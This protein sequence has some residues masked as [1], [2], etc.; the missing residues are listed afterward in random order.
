[1]ENKEKNFVSSVIY[2]HNAYGRIEEF[3]KMVISVMEG[4]FEHSEIICVNDFSDDDSLSVIRSVSKTAV[5]TSITIVNMSYFHGLELAMKAGMDM[6]IGDFVFEFDNTIMDYDPGEIYKIY[7][8][9]LEGY[10]IVSASPNK[11]EKFTSR[12]YYRTFDRFSNIKYEMVTESFRILS[13]R[14]INRIS[15]MNSSIL[16]RKA[17]YANCGLKTDCM[18]YEVRRNSNAGIDK[19]EK[20]FRSGLAVDSLILFTEVGYRFSMTM[21]AL[22]MVVSLLTIAYTIIIYLS[23]NPVAGWTTTILFLS[24]CFFGLFGILTIIIKYLQLLVNMVFKRK[25]YSFES[26][27]KLTD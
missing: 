24:F 1:M 6:A 16:Y 13:R 11:K 15:S 19:K 4:R 27:E 26:V 14:V 22:M 5:N 10:D 12:L 18:R 3:L 21:T 8:R 7:E 25:Q 17:L 20:S 2:V 23:A 9:A